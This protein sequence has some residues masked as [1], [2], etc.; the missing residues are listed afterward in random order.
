M[1]TKMCDNKGF[2]WSYMVFQDNHYLLLFVCHVVEWTLNFLFLNNT[3]VINGLMWIRFYVLTQMWNPSHQMEELLYKTVKL[4][5]FVGLWYCTV[6][7][8]MSKQWVRPL[9]PLLAAPG[10]VELEEAEEGGEEEGEDGVQEVEDGE[11]A[12]TGEAE[13]AIVVE[14]GGQGAIA[15]REVVCVML[16][17]F[18]KLYFFGEI[19]LFDII[20][21]RLALFHDIVSEFN[22]RLY[23]IFFIH[24]MQLLV[25]SRKHYI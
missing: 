5:G 4:T 3:Q 21:V 20:C 12:V 16:G 18:W 11:G 22:I 15:V 23:Y 6:S 14:D 7:R 19:T 9:C 1:I 8:A 13:E 2:L 17:I 24:P 10:V 25:K